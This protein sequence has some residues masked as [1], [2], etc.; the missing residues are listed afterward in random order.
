LGCLV[1]H[2][3]AVGS[4]LIRTR[5]LPLAQACWEVGAP[6]IRN[7]ATIAGNI[8]TASPAN[9]T[10]TPLMALDASVILHS[11]KDGERAV[12]LKDFYSGYR[13]TAMRP[14]EMLT[15]ISIPALKDSEAGIFLQLAL[16]RA[17]AI[18]VIDTTL[19][20]GFQSDRQSPIVRADLTIGA[21]APTIIHLTAAE[22]YLI[23]KTLSDEVI[24][25]TGRIA[26][27]IPSP[28]D[29]VRGPAEYRSQMISVYVS[30][31][32]RAIRHQKEGAA[33]PQNPAMLWGKHQ[34]HTRHALPQMVHHQRSDAET[35]TTTVN[36]Q[37]HTST[38]GTHKT[39][40][41]FLREDLKLIGTKEG[42]A[43][44]ECGACT[45]FLDDVAVMACMVPAPRAHGADIQ[46]IEG[47]AVNGNLHPIQQGFIDAGAVQCGF[48][49]PGFLMAGAKLLD[50]LPHPTREQV[51]QSIS[52]NLCRCTGYY[53]ILEAF[54]RAQELKGN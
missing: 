52:G 16:R 33:F 23:G 35:I 14:D 42:C 13:Q 32:L 45:V 8:I 12:R 31:S 34:A 43:E 40:L 22:D 38:G 10:I 37:T 28:I 41:R 3:H 27:G 25:E 39:L 2:N 18:S 4:E 47:L 1:T 17:Q 20:L 30:R 53:R 19:I 44:G 36:G 6:Q 24:A 5:A 21:V 48:C 15:A 29:D 51:E 49:T 9:D 46:T 54:D 7:R 50:E 26:A 11:K